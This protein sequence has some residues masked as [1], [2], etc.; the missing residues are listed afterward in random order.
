[1]DK[2]KPIIIK[3]PNCSIFVNNKIYI[4]F[5]SNKNILDKK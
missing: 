2:N 5:N 3:I 4:L 1:M